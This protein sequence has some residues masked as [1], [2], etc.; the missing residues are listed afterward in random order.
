MSDAIRSSAPQRSATS[1]A[2][3]RRV[4]T[5]SGTAGSSA[6]T[7]CDSEDTGCLQGCP[8]EQPEIHAVT[9]SNVRI[10]TALVLAAV[11]AGPPEGVNGADCARLPAGWRPNVAAARAWVTH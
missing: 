4:P 1:R 8:Q 7:V 9:I 3:R 5:L 10:L 11:L 2:K 6:R